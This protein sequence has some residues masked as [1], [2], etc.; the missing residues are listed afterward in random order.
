MTH[1]D[2]ENSSQS[3]DNDNAGRDFVIKVIQYLENTYGIIFFITTKDFDVLYR[4]YEKRIPIHIVKESISN[5]V[6]RWSQK[7]KKIYSFSNFYYEV[8]KN[9]KAFL[10]MSVG[11]ETEGEVSET[12]AAANIYTEIENFFKNYPDDL[13]TL[14]G[15]FEG[16]YQQVKNKENVELEPLYERLVDL[17][18]ED[19]ALNLKVTV[20]TQ[21]L[22]PELRKPEIKNR[23][24]LNYLLNKYNIPDFDITP[25]TAG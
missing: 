4:W 10:Q 21:S 6:E 5:V 22:A 18:K 16:I 24:R 17:F 23:Y 3:Y 15:E 11:R 2:N 1:S 25:L 13:V 12:E 14:K 8:K 7:N 9:F 20:F 19:E